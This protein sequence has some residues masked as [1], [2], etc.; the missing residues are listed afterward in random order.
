MLKKNLKYYN[1]FIGLLILL[2]ACDRKVMVNSNAN[3]EVDI[4][5]YTIVKDTSAK[6]YLA[7]IIENTIYKNCFFNEENLSADTLKNIIFENCKFTR[8]E[9]VTFK[10]YSVNNVKFINCS[11]KSF[12][13]NNTT[14]YSDLKFI[15]CKANDIIFDQ[16]SFNNILFTAFRD[17][18]KN[19]K[20]QSCPNS[21]NIIFDGNKIMNIFI[22]GGE[23]SG[24][25]VSNITNPVTKLSVF[26]TL[27]INPNF[28]NK[29]SKNYAILFNS[30]LEN[31]TF[32][33]NNNSILKEE[34]EWIDKNS[35]ES[36]LTRKLEIK[37]GYLVSKSVYSYLSK[38]YENDKKY[39]LA[40]YF[41]HR[42]KVCEREINYT[43]TK[44]YLLTLFDDYIRGNHGTNYFVILKTFFFVTILFA[45]IYII[46]GY[47][48]IAFGYF[49]KTNLFGENNYNEKP[50]ILTFHRNNYG[51]F[52]FISNC[53]IYSLNNMV[54]GG[55]SNGF[56]FYNFT[57]MYLYPPRKY[58]TVG[59][60]RFI[61]I[62]QSIVGLLLVVFFITSFLRLTR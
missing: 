55:L 4:N 5:S 26:A 3:S 8:N 12:Y 14:I 42:S 25:D 36:N 45:F 61:S 48:K 22:E 19:I 38:I 11:F 60:G 52:K 49:I 46:L 51:I 23:I 56:H 9:N 34:L 62:I 37:K 33:P 53:F 18:I 50:I 44:K 54:L 29:A 31:A 39:D 41:Y 20:L 32:L 1:L 40:D 6:I 2:Y 57:T 43:G 58:G 27:L 7:K 24:L 35:E 16:S 28:V 21:K 30:S 15:D 47:F 17:T 59:M 13:I 10:V